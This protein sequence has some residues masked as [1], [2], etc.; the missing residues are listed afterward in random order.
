MEGHHGL[1]RSSLRVRN[2]K[3]VEEDKA[4]EIINKVVKESQKKSGFEGTFKFKILQD[5]LQLGL[6]EQMLVQLL[7]DK[8]TIEN[9][10]N[11]ETITEDKKKKAEDNTIEKEKKKKSKKRK[12]TSVSE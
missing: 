7:P 12:K 1:E 4:R 8:F 2:E 11:E 3:A 10:R 6:R 9:K 5:E